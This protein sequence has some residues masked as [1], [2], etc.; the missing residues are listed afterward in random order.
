MYTAHVAGCQNIPLGNN[1]Y[2]MVNDTRPDSTKSI[3]IMECDPSAIGVTQDELKID[4]VVRGQENVIRR[5]ESSMNTMQYIVADTPS[6]YDSNYNKQS[7]LPLEDHR[8]TLLITH[9]NNQY[10]R[11]SHL[12]WEVYGFTGTDHS[13]H[14]HSE[15]S[16]NFIGSWHEELDRS[17]LFDYPFTTDCSL[18]GR[19][20]IYV[21][22]DDVCYCP[23]SGYPLRCV[24][25]N[26][27]YQPLNEKLGL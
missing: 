3:R 27:D 18:I 6:D 26:Y 14:T 23:L 16:S 20:H 9:S 13:N 10:V 21:D 25:R 4:T 7:W 22:M 12:V 11:Y 1:L 17:D 5:S 2:A 19:G 8:G 15:V 24:Y